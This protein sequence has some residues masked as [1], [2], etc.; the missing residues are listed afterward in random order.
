M[1]A[2]L[3]DTNRLIEYAKENKK[4]LKGYTTVFNIIEFPK[5]IEFF[6]NIDVL[7]PEQSDYDLAIK[8]AT[9]LYKIG[10]PVPSIDIIIGAIC[11]NS[12]LI[13]FSKDKHFEYIKE[14]ASELQIFQDD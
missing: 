3:F 6:S 10:K 1:G 9:E 4:D 11:I 14:V 13:L 8:I 12:N 7:Y 5:I 2:G